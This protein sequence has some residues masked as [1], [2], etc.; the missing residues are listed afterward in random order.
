[1][2]V[3]IQK[4]RKMGHIKSMDQD[5]ENVRFARKNMSNSPDDAIENDL[6]YEE[7]TRFVDHR[8]EDY[9]ASRIAFMMI[10]FGASILKKEINS[11]GIFA[12]RVSDAL[13]LGYDWAEKKEKA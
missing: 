6:I 12:A 2:T 4:L 5:L 8:N 13:Y 10:A 3:V 9:E 11:N 1:M 7:L